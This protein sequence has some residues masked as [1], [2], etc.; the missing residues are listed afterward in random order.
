MKQSLLPFLILG[1]LCF[2]CSKK[3]KESEK[4]PSAKHYE[5]VFSDSIKIPYLGKPILQDISPSDQKV[6]FIE[7]REYDQEIFTASFQ[8]EIIHSFVTHGNTIA[9]HLGGIA[10][11]HF[12]DDGNSFLSFG[13]PQVKKVS[14]DGS[15]VE[16]IFT[17]IPPYYSAFPVP[18]N[19]L[20]KR[21]NKIFFNNRSDEGTYNRY[22]KEYLPN[23][24]L[25]GYLDLDKSETT[26]FLSFPEESIY[27]NGLIFPHST[28]A[29]LF[30]FL[31]NEL[32]VA[33][34]G[35]PALF[36]FDGEEPFA[37][38]QKI[39]LKLSD[40]K[41]YKGNPEGE[42]GIDIMEARTSLGRI[43]SIKTINE[44][45]VIGYKQGFTDNQIRN[46]ETA[47]SP[48]EKGKM[49]REFENE[50]SSRIQLLDE[51]FQVLDD[52]LKPKYLNIS[53]LMV[54][55]GHL[56][57]SKFDPETEEDFFTIYKLEIKEKEKPRK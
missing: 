26:N 23:L 24:K 8:G 50:N 43:E 3:D 9:G 48:L 51:K 56:W 22:Q 18:A 20:V 21:N 2:S 1:L 42:K 4:E 11:L 39:E 30:I 12:E 27:Q 57:G 55:D 15:E 17:G 44:F 14:I 52:F 36:V 53:S 34:E 6:L 41:S 31:Q 40:F 35:E 19:E 32:I 29:S 5:I 25:I 28:W 45:I 47:T 38:K 10:P 37:F 33:F 7:R 49:I 13:T 54:R 16:T 46:L